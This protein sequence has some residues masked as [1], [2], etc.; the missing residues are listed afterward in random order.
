MKSEFK[1]LQDALLTRA[2]EILGEI[3]QL[4]AR[5]GQLENDAKPAEGEAE[6]CCPPDGPCFNL[7]QTAIDEFHRR[8]DGEEP[9]LEI[10]LDD[11]GDAVARVREGVHELRRCSTNRVEHVLTE[12]RGGLGEV[13]LSTALLIHLGNGDLKQ[14]VEI[15]LKESGFLG[16]E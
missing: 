14:A 7:T 6:G 3:N 8:N 1:K 2:T 9:E 4:K 15:S 5:V 16:E 10:A 13:L 12:I 11:F